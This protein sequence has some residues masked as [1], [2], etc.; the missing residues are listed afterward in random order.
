MNILHFT[1]KLAKSGLVLP[2]GK[3]RNGQSYMWKHGKYQYLQGKRPQ[4]RKK[5]CILCGVKNFPHYHEQIKPERSGHCSIF[6]R[7]RTRSCNGSISV[8]I[9]YESVCE[10]ERGQLFFGDTALLTS[11]IMKCNI[12]FPTGLVTERQCS[13][14]FLDMILQYDFHIIFVVSSHL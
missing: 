5:I 14:G 8:F 2:W 6:H 7:I 11:I 13:L 12:Y 3:E 4:W 1:L 9:S 10:R